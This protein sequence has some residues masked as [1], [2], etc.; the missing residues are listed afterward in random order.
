MADEARKCL[1]LKRRGAKAKFTRLGNALQILI[2]EHRPAAEVN[3][4]FRQFEEAFHD[5]QDKHESLTEITE[6]DREFNQEEEW[7]ERCQQIFLRMKITGK[8]YSQQEVERK[9]D[10]TEVSNAPESIATQQERS[11]ELEELTPP[12]QVEQQDE[13][14]GM[15]ARSALASNF[16]MEKMPKFNGD[17]REYCIFKADFRHV[18]SGRYH[19]RD[20]LM[21]LRSC[22]ECK[23]LQMVR[24]IGQDYEA[25]WEQL[26][27]IYGDP[28]FVADTIINDVSIF[29]QLK[30]GEDDRFCEFVNVVRRSY[31]TLKEIGKVNDMD[32]SHMLAIIERKMC[33]EDRK[34]WFRH[35]GEGESVSL[36]SLL[37]WM[38]IELKA[39]MRSTAPVRSETRS[40]G[41]NLVT[42]A[43]EREAG[44]G[45]RC[46]CCQNND[47]H[48]PDQCKKL[49]AKTQPERMR[50]VKENHVCFGCLKK[51][52]REHRMSNCKKRRHCMEK[53]NGDQCKFYHHPLLHPESQHGDIG[54]ALVANKEAVL[55]VIT[56]EFMG[57]E[58]KSKRGNLL[59][60]TGAQ[61]SLIKQSFAEELKLKGKK[62]SITITKVGG[63]KEVFQ[64]Y[65]YKVNVRA[66]GGNAQLHTVSAVGLP[67]INDNVA[68]VKL[69]EI[70]RQFKL[71]KG[72]LH[73]GGGSVDL[74]VGIDHAKM[75]GG[76]TREEGNIT[77]RRSPL[78]WVVFG[79]APG[80]RLQSGRV[81]HVQLSTSVDLS[82]FWSTESMGVQ[83][84]DCGCEPNG[85]SKI[86]KDEYDLISRSCEKV[87]NQWR[88]PYP[89]RKSPGLLPN[90]RVQAERML[91]AIE[92]KLA[93]NPDHAE[94]YITDRC[95]K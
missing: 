40:S 80:D 71:K 15:D 20:A 72:E 76:E 66:L 89:W 84:D 54:V 78:G 33:S 31:N 95:R 62:T 47:G 94:A 25:A 19:S 85:L 51:A 44:Q 81:L 90:N 23:P 46:W 29:R 5:L 28:R 67:C 63:D 93:K 59:L 56:V 17:I 9:R 35:Q 38:S 26:D 14:V 88:I 21:I 3:E 2:D 52:S 34:L 86:E 91:N 41:V 42:R 45:Y 79:A 60:D 49:I 16:Q 50:L 64:T 30:Q 43:E 24:G 11:V 58:N 32:N 53:F 36:Q 68:E 12:N 69:D 65:I 77:A 8:D 18:V 74:L 22:L 57:A 83:G 82:D 10:Q 39:R 6:D 7:M 70:A 55:P 92:K 27:L 13:S 61:I 73:R 48:W 87:E 1:R 4:D 37:K 75:H